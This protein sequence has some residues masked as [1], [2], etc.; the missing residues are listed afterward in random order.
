MSSFGT[1]YFGRKK[2]S[3]GLKKFVR[4][5]LPGISDEQL[6]RYACVKHIAVSDTVGVLSGRDEGTMQKCLCENLKSFG[7]IGQHAWRLG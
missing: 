7:R 3:K 1:I 2:K 5:T 6:C 4:S